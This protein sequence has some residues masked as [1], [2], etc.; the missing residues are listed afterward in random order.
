MGDSS[1]LLYL[2]NDC[3]TNFQ[4]TV[5]LSNVHIRSVRFLKGWRKG[6]DG[7]VSSFGTSKIRVCG[8]TFGH[9]IS[10]DA[11]MRGCQEE[12]KKSL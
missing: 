2:K 1:Q 4:N 12:E 9:N 5:D 7:K 6:G 10:L 3:L 8:K 11:Q